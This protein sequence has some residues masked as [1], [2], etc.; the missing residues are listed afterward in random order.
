MDLNIKAL[1]KR[2]LE[3]K[4]ELLGRLQKIE[5]DLEK[6]KD[7]DFDEMASER[8]NDEVLEGIGSAGLHEIEQINAALQR[9]KSGTYGNCVVCGEEIPEKRLEIIPYAVKCTA[10]SE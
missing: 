7:S 5:G 8:E 10:C 2:M 1:E 6:P 4:D 9:I 3:R